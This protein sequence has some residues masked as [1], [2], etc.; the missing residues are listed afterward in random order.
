MI[1]PEIQKNQ[2]Q[3]IICLSFNFYFTFNNI[4][5]QLMIWLIFFV[6]IVMFY[7]GLCLHLARKLDQ[8]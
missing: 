4:N 2:Q 1:N 7:A 8:E 6:Q 3:K 5:L